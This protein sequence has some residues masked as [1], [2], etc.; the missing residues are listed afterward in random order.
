LFGR[1]LLGGLVLVYRSD[2]TEQM[3]VG[4]QPTLT[5]S[6]DEAVSGLA[7]RGWAR[8][9]EAL[10]GTLTAQ[11]AEDHGR[12]WHVA[13]DEGV[14][15]QHVLG[16]YTP[17]A[18][19]P[20]VVRAVGDRLIAGLSS[21]AEQHGL[22]TL[23]RFNEAT[24]GRYP[25]GTGHITA[26]RDP[27]AYRGVIA[28]FTLYGQARFRVWDVDHEVTEWDTGPGQLVI[29]RGSGWPKADSR[30]PRHDVEPPKHDERMIMTLRYNS[31]G[32]GAGYA[33]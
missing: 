20:P 24:W 8:A 10:D 31:G 4:E 2:D 6:R 25:P 23:P 15:R 7:T 14:V 26:H 27:P 3:G 19:A 32:A 28:V 13:G 30:C 17:F 29:L 16:S 12:E 18:K 5:F 22:P 11:L 9:Q 21:A 1:F 33:V